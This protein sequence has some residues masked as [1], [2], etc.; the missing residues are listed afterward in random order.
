MNSF[1][2]T[3]TAA[4]LLQLF[5]KSETELMERNLAVGSGCRCAL[6]PPVPLVDHHSTGRGK[7]VA[8]PGSIAM[9]LPIPRIVLSPRAGMLSEL[10]DPVV[11]LGKAFTFG[12][13]Q[14]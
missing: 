4:T 1:E 5:F 8:L 9:S 13:T 2:L 7:L 12:F 3:P 6:R 10:P 11:E 14:N